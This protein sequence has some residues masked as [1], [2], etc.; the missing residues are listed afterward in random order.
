MSHIFSTK[1]AMSAVD[2]SRYGIGVVVLTEHEG[3]DRMMREY[4][5]KPDEI[6]CEGRGKKYLHKLLWK[7]ISKEDKYF[8]KNP[9][10]IQRNSERWEN[11]MDDCVLFATLNA[12]LFDQPVYLLHPQAYEKSIAESPFNATSGELPTLFEDVL[13]LQ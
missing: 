3:L 4:A 8:D 13:V 12:F 7:Q 6:W 5:S 2:M 11:F 1:K 9:E 10:A